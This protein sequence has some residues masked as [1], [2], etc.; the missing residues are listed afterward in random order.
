MKER[1][2]ACVQHEVVLYQIENT[3]VFVN[4]TFKDETFWLT[5][6]SMAELFGVNTQAITKH[7]LCPLPYSFHMSF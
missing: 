2:I 6:K 3:N 7:F 5:T 1:V 4:V